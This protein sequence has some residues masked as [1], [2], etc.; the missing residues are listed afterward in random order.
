[1][2]AQC[3]PFTPEA[4]TLRTNSEPQTPPDKGLF[5]FAHCVEGGWR[6]RKDRATETVILLSV[7]PLWDPRPDAMPGAS[8][9]G[10]V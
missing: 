6:G 4:H 8:V 1:M 3:Q 7:V 2:G 5:P 9:L 10:Q